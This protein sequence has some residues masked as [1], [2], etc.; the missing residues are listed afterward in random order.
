MH[1]RKSSS[2]DFL[3]LVPS[4][5]LRRGSDLL[6]S[7]GLHNWYR[8]NGFLDAHIQIDYRFHDE[9][10]KSADVTVNIR[11]GVQTMLAAYD[12]ACP[13]EYVAKDVQRAANQLKLNEP[14]N[15]FVLKQ[16]QYDLKAAYANAGHPYGEVLV[17]SNL[18]SNR[19]QIRPRLECRAG[20]RVRFGDVEI[21]ELKWTRPKAVRREIVFETGDLY[22]RREV[23]ESQQRL[24]SSGLFDYVTLEALGSNPE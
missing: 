16:V 20:P 8:S 21:P 9:N 5:R 12:V 11:E 13:E 23:L 17:D 4:R 7:A 6:D 22:S 14:F 3:P 10:R 1:T 18:S 15:P 19:R 24:Y 2:F